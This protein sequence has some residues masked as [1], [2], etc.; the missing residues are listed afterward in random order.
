MLPHFMGGCNRHT[1]KELWFAERR[2]AQLTDRLARSRRQNQETIAARDQRISELEGQLRS[3]RQELAKAQQSRAMPATV[4]A[5]PR[6][7]AERGGRRLAAARARLNLLEAEN[8]R[9]HAVLKVLIEAGP[10]GPASA[11]GPGPTQTGVAQGT[12]RLD[13]R[14]ILYVGGRCQLLPHLRARRVVQRLPAAPRRW[15]GGEPAIARTPGRSRGC[16]ALPD[17]LREPSGLPQG[18][19]AVPAARQAVR[20]VAQQQRHVFRARDRGVAE[21]TGAAGRG[22]ADPGQGLSAPASAA[23]KERVAGRDRR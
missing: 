13:G 8:Q 18:Q 9:L 14:C 17:R 6:R 12:P 4:G 1:A 22:P 15:P 19:G 7:A 11:S 16:R 3:I 23:T 20:A 21:H 10:P 2:L 5:P